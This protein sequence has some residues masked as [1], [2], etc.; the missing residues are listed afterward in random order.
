MTTLASLQNVRE[1]LDVAYHHGRGSQ[2]GRQGTRGSQEA[3]RHPH[4][5]QDP[6]R[7]TVSDIRRARFVH[8]TYSKGH[9]RSCSSPG[10]SRNTRAGVQCRRESARRRLAQTCTGVGWW[11][12]F[13]REVDN[14]HSAHDGQTECSLLFLYHRL[15][16]ACRA[17]CGWLALLLGLAKLF[18]VGENEVHVLFPK[19]AAILSRGISACTHLVKGQHLSNHLAA[20]LERHSHPVVDLVGGLVNCRRAGENGA[21]RR[22]ASTRR[23]VRSRPGWED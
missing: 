20:I 14:V 2:V 16:R 7:P 8:D 19:L 3:A 22:G 17:G 12:R 5:E 10:R 4:R 13:D 15:R 1:K 11:G 18:G 23:Y 9:S 6:T 21:D